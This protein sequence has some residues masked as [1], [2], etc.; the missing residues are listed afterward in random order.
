[1]KT[2]C[3]ALGCAALRAIGAQIHQT[4]QDQLDLT[5][6]DRQDATWL[7]EE[8]AYLQLLAELAVQELHVGYL[9][10]LADLRARHHRSRQWHFPNAR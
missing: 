4:W 8:S 3:R 10:R 9:A 7:R 6:A 1:M 5:R 2:L